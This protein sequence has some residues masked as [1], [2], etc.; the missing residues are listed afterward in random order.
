MV[1]IIEQGAYLSQVNKTGGG[2]F[3]AKSTFIST[4]YECDAVMYADA[5]TMTVDKVVYCIH[6]TP[7]NEG[8]IEAEIPEL[9][10]ASC[11]FAGN[12]AIKP[13]PDYDGKGFIKELLLENLRCI[14]QAEMYMLEEINIP[15]QMAYEEYWRDEKAN[16]C[17]PY[18]NRMPDIYEWPVHSNYLE[19]YRNLNLYNK[20]KQYT[21]FDIGG[22]KATAA[23]T[24]QDSFHEMYAQLTY[25]LE[26]REITDFDMTMRRWPFAACYEM[27]HM[28][29]ER[30][31]GRKIDELSKKV[32]GGLIGGSYGCFHLTD[33]VADMA[34]AAR[35]LKEDSEKK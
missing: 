29:S 24:Y 17:R 14:N 28:W 27:D 18:T 26:D 12:K 9:V 5:R 15:D 32:T 25:H 16:Y 22:G 30:F 21:I 13:L 31:V 7:G 3:A 33:I 2:K 20:Y 23:G 35:D 34:K 6:R 19:H 4:R 8:L 11:T 1:K 10:G